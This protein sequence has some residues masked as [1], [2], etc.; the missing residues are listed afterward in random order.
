[1]S[2]KELPIDQP[3]RES[4][5]Q[6]VA[7]QLLDLINSGALKPGDQ[8]PSEPDLRAQFRVGR[9][10][11]REA[12]NGLVLIGAIEV[13]H[14]QGAFVLANH[15]DKAAALDAA[16]R[17]SVTNELLE[18]RDAMELT[19]ARLAA[20]RATESDLTALR[21]LLDDAERKIQAGGVAFEEAARF[22]LLLAE[23]AQ[24]ELFASFVEMILGY[25]SERG[26]DLSAS[27][28]YNIWELAA[29]RHV[30]DA[31]ASKDGERAQNSMREHLQDMRE[32]HTAG[33][34]SFQEAHGVGSQK[35]DAPSARRK[36][37]GSAQALASAGGDAPAASIRR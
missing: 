2:A 27:P 6:I 17:R 21:Q 28:E 32:I 9:S 37:G 36:R 12:L 24:N 16:V 15:F 22:H 35:Q 23:A 4:L 11:I 3:V 7:R 10:T 18:A 29:H 8:L 13:R 25:L 20:E 26:V 1:M 19:I 34:S 14:G 5:P 33:W 30:L 31:V